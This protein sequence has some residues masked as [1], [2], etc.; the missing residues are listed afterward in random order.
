MCTRSHLLFGR[1]DTSVPINWSQ[2]RHF[3]KT[4]N[5]GNHSL[6]VPDLVY[7]LDS[8]RKYLSTPILISRGTQ[9]QH[10]FNS[11]HYWKFGPNDENE[12]PKGLA[13]DILFPKASKND[14]PDLFLKAQKLP[15]G[16][17]GIYPHWKYQDKTIGGMHVDL[18]P[19]KIR[20]TWIGLGDGQ[21]IGVTFK[22][23]NSYFGGHH[24]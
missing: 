19:D 24:D 9:G 17:V 5:W 6:I 8:L 18:R 7:M 14:L 22:N 16:G 1:Y 15:F 20:A 11:Y 4:D 3:S 23:L 12:V 21:Y 10:V 13:A 2:V